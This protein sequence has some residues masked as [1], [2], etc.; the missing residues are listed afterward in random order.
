MTLKEKLNLRKIARIIVYRNGNVG[1]CNDSGK[2]IILPNGLD[3]I[4]AGNIQGGKAI[5]ELVW[6]I[7]G[8]IFH[9]VRN[10]NCLLYLRYDSKSYGKHMQM[11][12]IR[13]I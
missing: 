3:K 8:E 6:H 2:T 11:G 10:D 1:F 7:T 4:D 5:V 12:G 13:N 9:R